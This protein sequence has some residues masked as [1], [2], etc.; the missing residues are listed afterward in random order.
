MIITI[1]TKSWVTIRDVG[2]GM[3]VKIWFSF[4]RNAWHL[5][6]K[7]SYKKQVNEKRQVYQKFTNLSQK[8]LHAKNNKK[9]F[10]RNDVMTT[11]IKR[12]RGEKQEV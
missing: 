3:G 10:V 12:R 7:K 8:Q 5:W 1:T 4:K 11:Y 6:N 9:A 2:S